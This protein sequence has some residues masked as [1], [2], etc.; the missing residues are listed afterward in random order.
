[1]LRKVTE[2]LT[3]VCRHSLRLPVAPVGRVDV[4]PRAGRG[5]PPAFP[6][7]YTGKYK[8]MLAFFVEDGEFE[9]TIERGA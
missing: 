2:G 1:M 5:V 7:L 6:S 8:R 4:D 3:G 9:I